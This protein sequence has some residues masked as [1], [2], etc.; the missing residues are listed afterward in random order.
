LVVIDGR[1]PFDLLKRFTWMTDTLTRALKAC[2]LRLQRD[3]N[4]KAAG[5]RIVP[6]L[7]ADFDRYR[8]WGLAHTASES[9]GHC[10]VTDAM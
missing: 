1:R 7:A 6:L 8:P 9:A 10:P 2:R 5:R 4:E 3:A